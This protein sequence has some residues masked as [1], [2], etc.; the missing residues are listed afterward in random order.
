M[1]QLKK[2]ARKLSLWKH[3]LALSSNEAVHLRFYEK[4]LLRLLL[5]LSKDTKAKG[6]MIA[7]LLLNEL[8]V[9]V[10]LTALNC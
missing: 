3:F 8:V 7:N 6:I 1:I 4:K 5:R 2:S 9:L 10:D